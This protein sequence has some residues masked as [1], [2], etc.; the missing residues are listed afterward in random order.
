LLHLFNRHQILLRLLKI[1]VDLGERFRFFHDTLVCYNVSQICSC[2]GV[3][4]G[5]GDFFDDLFLV[6]DQ[7]WHL[8]NINRSVIDLHFCRAEVFLLSLGSELEKMIIFGP[9]RSMPGCLKIE[10]RVVTNRHF[11]GAKL[12]LK[13]LNSNSVTLCCR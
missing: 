5:R 4:R 7:Y 9:Q 10:F 8:G 12:V 6:F 13:D 2:V 1:D 3:L 11:V